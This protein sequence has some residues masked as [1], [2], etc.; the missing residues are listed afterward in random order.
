[1][2]KETK[3]AM[4]EADLGMGEVV[5]IDEIGD[6]EPFKGFPQDLHINGIDLV[7]IKKGD[8]EK[9]IDVYAESRE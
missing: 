7:V 2:N 8:Y 1:M 4:A 3:R 5:A 9:L 6:D